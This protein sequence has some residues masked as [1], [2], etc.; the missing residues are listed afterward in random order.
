MSDY[1]DPGTGDHVLVDGMIVERDALRIAEAIRDYDE[2]LVVLCVDPSHV[3][4]ISEEPFVIAE[5]DPGGVLRPVLRCWTLD[6]TVLERLYLADQQNFNG[7]DQ[8]LRLEEQAKSETKSRYQE[9]REE[10]AD[11]V[12]HIAGMRSKYSVKDSNTGELITFFDDRP[13]ERR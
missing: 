11:I 1:Y 2:N 8:L 5:R 13:A 9:I 10:N 4:G 7:F 3:S 6:D 12:K